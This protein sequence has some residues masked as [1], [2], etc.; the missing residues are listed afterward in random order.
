MRARVARWLDTL[1][2]A[3]TLPDDSEEERLGKAVLTYASL[4]IT[5][6]SFF[7]VTV[8]TYLGLWLAAAIPLAYQVI[9]TASLLY[10]I[11][12]KR[13]VAFR[14][15]QTL[16]M[17]MLPFLL[18]W[19]VGGFMA[20]SGVLL[21]A[22]TSPLGALL[23]LGTRQ[24]VPWFA[25]YVGLTVFSA[26][27]DGYLS[28][29]A[30]DVPTPLAIVIFAMNILG[31][32]LTAF[33]LTRYF[34][35]RR[36]LA[37][38]ALRVEQARS[39]RLLLNV[40]P[41]PVAQ[42]L[43]QEPGVIA[44]TF[45]EVTILFADIVGFTSLSE[46]VGPEE[47]V[48]W[49]NDVFSSFDR[50]ARRHGLEKIRTIGDSYMAVA[51]VPLPHPDHAVATAEVALGMLDAI[52]GKTAPNGEPLRI[53]IGIN[54]GPVVGAVIGLDKFIYDV[55]GDAVNTASRME[56]RG[57]P[58]QIQVSEATY[59]RL[60]DRYVFEERRLEQVR[61]KGD[62]SAY[63]LI[64]RKPEGDN[65]GPDAMGI[66]RPEAPISAAPVQTRVTS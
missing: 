40:L 27:I 23:F 10:F 47:M 5:L 32:S 2:N 22:L 50:L 56:S 16:M 58:G 39:E 41:A 4:L 13:Y 48:P 61:G 37:M 18:Q 42:R 59:L 64:G 38:N 44:D 49:L 1:A 55:Y 28:A 29:G 51:G 46:R 20:S 26:A 60:C 65:A 35:R 19:T 14:F 57:L 21:W 9:S 34:A 45:D 52:A 43:K 8:Y 25:A 6:L 31:V 12:T 54:T 63:I 11:S 36:E 15:V 62:M 7:W 33:A 3:G 24:A 17:L 30:A 53:R 66:E